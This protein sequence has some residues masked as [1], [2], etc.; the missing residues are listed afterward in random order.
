ASRPPDATTSDIPEIG[1]ILAP[2]L[3]LARC[4]MTCARPCH[5]G[6]RCRELTALPMPLA[7]SHH[8]PAPG[9]EMQRQH[10]GGASD[11][12]CFVISPIGQPG[13]AIRDHAD[14]VFECIIRPALEEMQITGRRADHIKDVGRI[15]R[16]IYDD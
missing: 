2:T 8:R 3:H 13:S 10:P 15:T 6:R 1:P 5:A 12:K 4:G 7:Y 11:M 16:Q 9:E 14:D